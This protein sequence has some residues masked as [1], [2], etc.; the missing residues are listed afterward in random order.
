MT[1]DPMLRLAAIDEEDLAVV[2]AHVQDAVLKVGDMVY[3][4]EDQALRR[5]HEPVYLGEGRGRQPPG[6]RAPARRC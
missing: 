4:P 1:D 3:L 5:R 2:S 6:F